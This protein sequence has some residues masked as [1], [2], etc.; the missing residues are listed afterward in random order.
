VRLGG[1]CFGVGSYALMGLRFHTWTN[2]GCLQRGDTVS[3][4]AP[5]LGPLNCFVQEVEPYSPGIVAENQGR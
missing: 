3:Y 4:N 1:G 5:G 2:L